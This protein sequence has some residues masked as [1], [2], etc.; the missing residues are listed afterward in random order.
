ML[1]ALAGIGDVA[2]DIQALRADVAKL[3][4]SY[5][6]RP[7]RQLRHVPVINTDPAV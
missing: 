5:P 1:E 2:D 7:R 3:V 6:E 4:G